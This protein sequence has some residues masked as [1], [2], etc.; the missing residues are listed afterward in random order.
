MTLC[1]FCLDNDG[2]ERPAII[3]WHD[4]IQF[5]PVCGDCLSVCVNA[6]PVADAD[7]PACGGISLGTQAA[8]AN[9]DVERRR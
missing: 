5:V 8:A 6:E 7:N 2:E 9:E 1:K 3:D 4:G